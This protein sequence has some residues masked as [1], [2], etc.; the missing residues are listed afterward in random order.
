MVPD[1]RP[2]SEIT[3]GVH[4]VAHTGRRKRLVRGIDRFGH[5]AT[6]EPSAW[7]WVASPL[8][9]GRHQLVQ[10]ALSEIITHPG[11]AS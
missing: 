9:L 10:V 1:T 6:R 2:A 11:R 3:A 8:G 4:A 7:V 5:L